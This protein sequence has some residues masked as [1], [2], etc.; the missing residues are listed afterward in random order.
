MVEL[1]GENGSRHE[2]GINLHSGGLCIDNVAVSGKMAS[3]TPHVHVANPTGGTTIDA[4][5]R[6]AIN[7]IL[8]ALETFGINASV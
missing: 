4:E 2:N 5:S 7:A 3:G 1:N 8:V 6:T